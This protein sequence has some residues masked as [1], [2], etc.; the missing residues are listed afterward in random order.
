MP[1]WRMTPNTSVKWDRRS[2]IRQ[3]EQTPG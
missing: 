2:F 1:P 3:S